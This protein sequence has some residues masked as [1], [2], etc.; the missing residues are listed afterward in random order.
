MARKTQEAQTGLKNY[1]HGDLALIGVD[2]LPNG[3]TI[4]DDK[5]LL[6]GSHGHPHTYDVGEFYPHVNGQ[7]IIGYL[8]AKKT[9]LHHP[10]HGEA[11]AGK[12][13]RPAEIADGIY[14]LRHQHEQTHEGMHPV[15]D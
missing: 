12:S 2:K 14:E 6:T 15:V 8:V 3:L 4:S 1:R 10:E 11:V 7:F 5:V 9:T 13:L